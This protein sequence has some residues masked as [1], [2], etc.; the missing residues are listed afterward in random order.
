MNITDAILLLFKQMYNTL[1]LLKQENKPA[2]NEKYGS[3][4]QFLSK[5]FTLI[6]FVWKQK[7]KKRG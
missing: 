6:T 1:L 3:V 4:Y 2:W 5:Q 7:D